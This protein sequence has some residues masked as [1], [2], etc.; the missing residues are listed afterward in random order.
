MRVMREA[1]PW[2][3]LITVSWLLLVAAA[4]VGSMRQCRAAVEAG[5]WTGTC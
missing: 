5:T 4:H 2:L 3:A 1:A